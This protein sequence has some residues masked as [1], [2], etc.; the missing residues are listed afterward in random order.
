MRYI[1][2]YRILKDIINYNDS[3]ITVDNIAIR[4][5]TFTS[6]NWKILPSKDTGDDTLGGYIF[7]NET[8]IVH[9]MLAIQDSDVKENITFKYHIFAPKEAKKADKVILLFHGFNEKHWHKYLPWA[10]YL[11]KQTGKAVVLFPIA[12]HMNRAPQVW[13]DMHLMYEVSS[14]RKQLFPEIICSTLSNAAIRTRMHTQPQRFI[15]SGLQTYYDVIQF[16]E[17]FKA[18]KHPLISSNAQ[19]DLFAYSIGA[20]LA[21]VLMMTNHNNYFEHSKL[22]MFCGGAVFNRL[23]PV[24]KFILDSQANVNLYSYI[25]EHLESHLKKDKKLHFYL[26]E[27]PEGTAFKSMLNYGV[28]TDFRE[29]LFKN[30]SERLFAIGLKN[31]SVVPPHEIA[32]TLQGRYR[33]IP[34]K[35]EMFDLPY[36]YK[37][38][39]PFPF[40][41]KRDTQI[42]SEFNRI[43]KPFGNFLK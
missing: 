5:Y 43:F 38:E 20:F 33:D 34:V 40:S 28:M 4:N 3:L 22:A 26:N 29:E 1:N 30:M 14:R 16:I 19:V 41:E 10:Q 31:D 2:T 35:I 36:P 18:D 9:E 24:S 23:S 27:R 17:E 7:N 32:N 21:E 8:G 39:D 15:W 37:H 6:D 42:D 25:V 12:F 13:S 11:V